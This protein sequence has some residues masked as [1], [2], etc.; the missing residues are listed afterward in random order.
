MNAIDVQMPALLL[1][2]NKTAAIRGGEEVQHTVNTGCK[3][4]ERNRILPT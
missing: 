4:N 1:L 3:K 2:T